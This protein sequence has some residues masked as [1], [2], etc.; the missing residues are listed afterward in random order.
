MPEPAQPGDPELWP[1]IFAEAFRAD[2]G[3]NVCAIVMYGSWLRGKR[4]TVLD[5]YV[6]LE[7][8]GDFGSLLERTANRALAPNVYNRVITASG[9]V[10]SAKFATLTLGHLERAITHDFH[11]YFW[12]RFAQ[13]IEVIYVRDEAT[14]LRVA[15][16]CDQ[17]ATRMIDETTP[18]FTGEFSQTELWQRAFSLTYACELRSE[19]ARKSGELAD[20]YSEHLMRMTE[21]LAT[22]CGLSVRPGGR[23]HCDAPRFTSPV[24]RWRLRRL[25]GK[26]LSVARL[27]KAAFTF[28]QP[29]EYILW[30]VERHSGV[31]EQ[32]SEL[33]CRFP[34]LFAWPV[35]WR[36]Y[37]RGGFR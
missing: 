26:G 14:R 19:D 29:L 22:R 27:F 8:Y 4:D 9:Q 12:A 32:P 15:H 33:Q 28:N 6:L 31:R 2:Y 1:G 20:N 37:R 7:D 3:V 36:I 5:F 34:L 17:A 16:A 23:W 24:W 30:K 25:V 11:S 18:M 21:K 35:L 13:P 10:C